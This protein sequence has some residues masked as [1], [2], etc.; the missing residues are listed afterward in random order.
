M[1]IL[2]IAAAAALAACTGA[3]GII[4]M[5]APCS[6]YNCGAYQPNTCF[7]DAN[8]VPSPG[9]YDYLFQD[10]NGNPLPPVAQPYP[11]GDP[12]AAAD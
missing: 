2:R 5:D 1:R 12:E 4:D 7:H 8:G 11:E 10:E 9:C 6:T 3:C